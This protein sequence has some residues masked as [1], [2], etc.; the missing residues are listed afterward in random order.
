VRPFLKKH[1]KCKKFTL[2]IERP[3]L[4]IFQKKEETVY[5]IYAFKVNL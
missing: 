4:A 1:R 3:K 2:Y 5:F